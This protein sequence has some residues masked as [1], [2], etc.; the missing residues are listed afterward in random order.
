MTDRNRNTTTDTSNREILHTR[1]FDAPRE[2]VF[3]AW[4]SPEKIGHWWGPNGF[5]TTTHKM[6]FRQGGVWEG[7]NG[8]DLQK[9]LKKHYNNTQTHK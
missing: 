7:P 1:T 3:D 2:L 5:T 4:T 6:E 9:L 8:T